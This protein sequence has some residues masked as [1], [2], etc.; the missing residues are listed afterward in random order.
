MYI[1]SFQEVLREGGNHIPFPYSLKTSCI[2]PLEVPTLF[3]CSNRT[4]TS[5]F[6]LFNVAVKPHDCFSCPSP[7]LLRFMPCYVSHQVMFFHN[8]APK[9]LPNGTTVLWLHPSL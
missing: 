1:E 9:A 8:Q 2:K 7:M 6:N 5:T 3:A 4:E